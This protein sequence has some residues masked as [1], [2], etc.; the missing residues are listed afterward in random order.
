MNN[1]SVAIAGCGGFFTL[2]SSGSSAERQFHARKLG[3]I[4]NP[5]LL[6]HTNIYQ[7]IKIQSLYPVFSSLKSR[8]YPQW[9]GYSILLQ[10]EELLL[11]FWLAYYNA[12]EP[13]H[14]YLSAPYRLLPF[15]ECCHLTDAYFLPVVFPDCYPAPFTAIKRYKVFLQSSKFDAY[16]PVLPS[17]SHVSIYKCSAV[18]LNQWLPEN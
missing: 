8:I 3:E 12:M 5:I 2:N 6:T 4:S 15:L 11:G 13:S 1:T 7:N 18:Y 17:S 10:L 14:S 9:Q 16:L